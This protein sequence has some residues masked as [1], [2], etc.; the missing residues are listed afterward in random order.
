[1]DDK[2]NVRKTRKP[3]TKQEAVQQQIE[4]L[5]KRRDKISDLA[6]KHALQKEIMQLFAQYERLKL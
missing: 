5:V 6:E 1:M 2:Y 4:E 3:E